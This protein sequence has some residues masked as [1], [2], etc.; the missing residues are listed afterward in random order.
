MVVRI[1]EWI[2]LRSLSFAKLQ[3]TGPVTTYTEPSTGQTYDYG[4]QIFS[5]LSVVHNFFS[6]FE[7]PLVRLPPPSGGNTTMINF[8]TGEVVA[9]SQLYM[10]NLT[11]ALLGYAEQEAKYSS[12]FEDWNLP[13]PVPEDLLMPF[14]DFLKKHSLEAFAYIAFIYDQGTA[15]ILAQPTLYVMKYQD[16]VQIRDLLTGSFVVNAL[17]NNQLLYD[18]AAA[19][20]GEKLYLGSQ[21]TQVT[22]HHNH[23]EIEVSTPEGTR[24]IRA[25][26]LLV[27]IPPKSTSQFLDFD[28][29]E[30]TMF[31]QF[32]NSYYWNAILKH[33]GIPVG[34]TLPNVNP[35]AS[36]NIPAMP[37]P[38]TFLASPVPG[39]HATY[40][41]SPHNMSDAEVADD[42]LATLARVREGAGF[43]EPDQN[44]EIVALHKWSPFEITVSMDAIRDGF[45]NDLMALQGKKNTWYTGA[46]WMNQATSTL[47]RY[48]EDKILPHLVPDEALLNAQY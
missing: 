20:L 38:Y 44:P 1:H 6:H 28:E 45:Y 37:A 16:Q 26:K 41:S 17:Q 12:I 43:P 2:S 33:T 9:P 7:I 27:T 25:R 11:A 3:C 19:E 29:N 10:G 46:T 42:I 39:L 40:Y 21:P 13:S 22:R 31:R 30:S 23:V 48:T 18:R 34:T 36:L 24:H 8:E 47:W 32:N 15:N 35:A 5:N 14:G 4:V